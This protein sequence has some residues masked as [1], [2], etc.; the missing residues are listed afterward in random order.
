MNPY[1]GA[2]F[3]VIGIAIG[4]ILFKLCANSLRLDGG[5]VSMHSI[6]L[7]GAAIVLY[8]ITSIAWVLVLRHVDLGRVYPV[9]ALAFI[10]VPAGSHF[11]LGERFHPAYFVGVLFIVAGVIITARSA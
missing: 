3:C 1:L 8:G 7:M 11:L 6:Y 5:T 10:F 2:F 9:M 4:Q